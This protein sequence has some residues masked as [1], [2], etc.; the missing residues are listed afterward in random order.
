[1]DFAAE[2]EADAK[3]AFGTGLG[4]PTDAQMKAIVQALVLANM[5]G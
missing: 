1:V 5:C 3:A 2:V 4:A